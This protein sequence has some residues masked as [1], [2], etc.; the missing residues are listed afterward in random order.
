MDHKESSKLASLRWIHL[1]L[2]G[3][4]EHTFGGMT[5]VLNLAMTIVLN[6][7]MTIVLN[8]KMTIVLNLE[9]TIVLNLAMKIVY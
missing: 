4:H 8:L 5:K 9:M 2:Q 1:S 7:A 6:L 3:N